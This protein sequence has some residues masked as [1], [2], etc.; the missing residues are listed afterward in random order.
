MLLSPSVEESSTPH[1]FIGNQT[2]DICLFELGIR[3]QR[4]GRYHKER[5]N[6]IGTTV[7]VLLS[8]GVH[9]HF[10][11]SPLVIWTAGQSMND[12]LNAQNEL[13]NDEKVK[14]VQL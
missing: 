1:L 4:T 9:H 3:R 11:S 8:S 6:G 12:L 5:N 10:P 13:I 14:W 2:P 7:N